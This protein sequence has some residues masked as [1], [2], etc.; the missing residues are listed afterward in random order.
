MYDFIKGKVVEKNPAFVVLENNGIG[1]TIHISLNTFTAIGD[2]QQIRLFTHLAIREDAHVLYGFYEHAERALFLQLI[3]VSGVGANT[4]RLILSSLSTAEAIEAIATEKVHILQSVKGIGGKT[5]QR[6][7]VDLRDKVAKVGIASE[8]MDASYNT[9]KA[10]ALS[11]LLILGFNK[12]S[13]EKVL[14]K[15]LKLDE[16]PTVEKLIK[17]ALKQL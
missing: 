2:Q 3:S 8:K 7:V 6:I 16:S 9:I 10:E 11:G 15:L 13:V 12:N 5:A 1:Y 17:E 14:D 4:A